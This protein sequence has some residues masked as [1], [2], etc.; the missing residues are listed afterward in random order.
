MWVL[1][2][3]EMM[4]GEWERD[5]VD[6]YMKFAEGLCKTDKVLPLS[7]YSPSQ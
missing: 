5:L 1:Y 2:S 3:V 7:Q 6:M 4:R